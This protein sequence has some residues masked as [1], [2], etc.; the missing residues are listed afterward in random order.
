MPPADPGKP[1][2]PLL[3]Q[4]APTGAGLVPAL[5]KP[6]GGGRVASAGQAGVDAPAALTSPLTFLAL[7]KAFRRRFGMA[8]TLGGLC[9]AA[10][11]ITAWLLLPPSKY[12][13]RA[14]LHIASNRPQVLGPI[15]E[16]SSDFPTY[17]RIQLALVK[18]RLVLIAAV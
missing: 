18:S 8:V 16:P 10:A 2:S 7:L 1:P 12:E 5:P 15:P 14:L 17:Q 3:P 13:A 11:I 6:A 4:A 9:A